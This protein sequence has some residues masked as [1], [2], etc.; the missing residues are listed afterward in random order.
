MSVAAGVQT[1][2]AYREAKAACG[3][4]NYSKAADILSGMQKSASLSEDQ[5]EF[6]RQQ[7]MICLGHL[8]PQAMAPKSLPHPLTPSSDQRNDC[9]PRALLIACETLGVKT[10]LADLTKAAGTDARGTSL[11]G[12]K[13]AAVGLKLKSEGLQVSREEFPLVQTPCICWT[14]LN[15]YVVV[16]GFAGHGEGGTATVQDPNE[17]RPRIVSQEKLL[18]ESGGYLITLRR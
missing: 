18:Q 13:R 5:K 15:H 4:S 2:A 7:Q 16:S 10:S 1:L 8:A 3:L 6:C 14:H 9:G 12:L 11:A 17:L